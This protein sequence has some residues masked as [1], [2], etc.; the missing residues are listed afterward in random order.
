MTMD[1]KAWA[2]EAFEECDHAGMICMDCAEKAIK[3]AVAE[4]RARRLNGDHRLRGDDSLHPLEGS[5]RRAER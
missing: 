5:P 2:T 4:E 3:A 1:A